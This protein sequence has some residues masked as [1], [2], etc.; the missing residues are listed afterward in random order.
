[1]NNNKLEQLNLSVCEGIKI[2]IYLS[3]NITSDQYDKYDLKSGYYND[4]CYSVSSNGIDISLPD[5]KKEFIENN[6]TLC[7]EVLR[8]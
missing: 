4:I 6:L 3:V 7:E 2:E 5:R 8:S 1:M